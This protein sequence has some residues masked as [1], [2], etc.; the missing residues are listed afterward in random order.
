MP[1]PLSLAISL[2]VSLTAQ[3]PSAPP[4]DA[5]PAKPDPTAPGAPEPTTPPAQDAEPTPP[6]GQKPPTDT[7]PETP[8]PPPPPAQPEAPRGFRGSL[9]VQAGITG[10]VGPGVAPTF[11]AYFDLAMMREG[12]FAPSLRL[13]FD[14]AISSNSLSNGGSHDYLLAGGSARVCPI[15]LPIAS[16][17]R[18]APCAGLVLGG[19]RGGTD[20]VVNAAKVANLWVAPTLGLTVDWAV[21]SKISLELSGGLIFPLERQVFIFAPRTILHEVPEVTGGVTVGGRFHL[22]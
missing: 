10:G 13:G 17:L 12:I 18:V 19:Y 22:F 7:P 20:A 2:F 1:T 8:P 3:E 14:M 6:E 15:Y 16:T 9:G 5:G 21:H 4:P 11:G